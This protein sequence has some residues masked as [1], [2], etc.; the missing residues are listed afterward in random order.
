[1]KG[2][3]Q[4]ADGVPPNRVNMVV[5]GRPQA[6]LYNPVLT[7]L[8]PTIGSDA[9]CDDLLSCHFLSATAETAQKIDQDSR[10]QPQNCGK[11]GLLPSF[12]RLRPRTPAPARILSE[13]RYLCWTAWKKSLSDRSSDICT[14]MIPTRQYQ[15]LQMGDEEPERGAA[16]RCETREEPTLVPTP[17]LSAEVH[18]RLIH[19]LPSDRISM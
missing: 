11:L 14:C 19:A 16:I 18:R 7:H 8:P 10:T 1:M 3:K 4:A 13:H 9:T 12:T 17:D 2:I 5:R 6:S 15:W